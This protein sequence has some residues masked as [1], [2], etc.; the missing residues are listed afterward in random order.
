MWF[1]TARICNLLAQV[2]EKL[3][4]SPGGGGTT[5]DPGTRRVSMSFTQNLIGQGEP[6]G[7]GRGLIPPGASHVGRRVAPRKGHALAPQCTAGR[8]TRS[9]GYRRGRYGPAPPILHSFPLGVAR[10]LPGRSNLTWPLSSLPA[11][12]HGPGHL[13]TYSR[14]GIKP[15]SWGR[16]QGVVGGKELWRGGIAGT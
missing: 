11:S 14:A 12:C 6:R 2:R 3:P 15:L 4:I 5:S 16:E 9:G 7:R 10:T 8:V 1:I 13:Q